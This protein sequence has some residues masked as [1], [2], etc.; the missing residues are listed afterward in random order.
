VF[1]K[2]LFLGRLLFGLYINDTISSLNH[3]EINLFAIDILLSN[4]SNNVA[5]C[6][7]K[8]NE[9]LKRLSKWLRFNQLKLDMTE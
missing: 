7:Q 8:M 1:H 6:I 9:D 5:D 4:A 2:G 3:S